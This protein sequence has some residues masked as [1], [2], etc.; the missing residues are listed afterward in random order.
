MGFS[1]T[2][3]FDFKYSSFEMRTP[4]KFSIIQNFFAH[5]DNKSNT[6]NRNINKQLTKIL[7]SYFITIYRFSTPSTYGRVHLVK[8]A[9]NIVINAMKQ[10]EATDTKT[11][12]ERQ[13]MTS[14]YTCINER[15]VSISRK[16]NCKINPVPPLQNK[17]YTMKKKR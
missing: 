12:I 10:C 11:C 15:R 7:T 6:L 17:P 4:A 16:G 1:S 13:G 5:K 3:C 9:Q 2:F 8:S 14:I